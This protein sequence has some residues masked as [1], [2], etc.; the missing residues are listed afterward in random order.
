MGRGG[1]RLSQWLQ[2]KIPRRVRVQAE[3]YTVMAPSPHPG[4]AAGSPRSPLTIQYLVAALALLAQLAV[5][6]S[7]VWLIVTE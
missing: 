5:I 3:G 1:S 7:L 2:S 4:L 6:F